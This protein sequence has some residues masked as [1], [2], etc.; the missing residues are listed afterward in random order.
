MRPLPWTPVRSIS[1]PLEAADLS[2]VQVPLLIAFTVSRYDA[3]GA[4]S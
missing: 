2:Q 1:T 4:Q 3:S